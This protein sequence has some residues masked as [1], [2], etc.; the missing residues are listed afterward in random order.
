ME[1]EDQ[2]RQRRLSAKRGAAKK[3]P[4]QRPVK[5]D[6]PSP[7]DSGVGQTGGSSELLVYEGI[8]LKALAKQ[9]NVSAK[10][11]IGRMLKK[12]LFLT[13]NQRLDAQLI[14]RVG[15]QLGVDL[16]VVK[17]AS[18]ESDD[19]VAVPP[20]G[21]SQIEGHLHIPPELRVS[22]APELSAAQVT[23]SLQ[24]LADYFRACGGIGLRVE[25]E[26][27]EI[28]IREMASV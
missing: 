25:Y 20:S 19:A 22:F 13:I 1:N 2:E 3:A 24:A 11:V 17:G 10:D 5:S 28:G 23:G 12:G 16:R 7:I 6:R 26:A 27:I 9:L 18:T 14:K 4:E 8:S 15:K 21:R